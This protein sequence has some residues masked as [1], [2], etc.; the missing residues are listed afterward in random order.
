MSAPSVERRGTVRAALA[1]LSLAALAGCQLGKKE[2]TQ[3]GYRGYA[4]ELN[5]SAAGLQASLVSNRVPAPLPPAAPGPVPSP[6]PFKNVQVLNDVSV[7]EFTRT[8]TAMS[9]WVAPTTGA[10]AGCLYCHNAANFAADTGYPQAYA[11]VVARRMLQM[12]RH[13]N[14]D[15]SAHVSYTGV[16]CYTCHR[17]QPQPKGLWWF[18]E[19]DEYLRAYL[20]RND[21]RVQSH[22]VGPTPENRSSIK[23]TNW[24]YALMI[25]QTQALGVN[26]T[27]CHSSRQFQSWEQGG[28]KRVIAEY[29][30]WMV[31]DLNTSYLQPLRPV[32]PTNLV[33]SRLG[34]MGDGPKLQC[35]TCHNGVYKP[36]YGVSMAKDYPALWGQ[37]TWDSS[38]V[39]L[40]REVYGADA[41]HPDS[42]PGYGHEGD[43]VA[44]FGSVP[45]PLPAPSG[46]SM[47][48]T[49]TASGPNVQP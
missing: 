40:H 10:N 44:P 46:G 39:D 1:V 26:C 30:F 8:M 15:W 20:D 17:G 37:A 35:V 45:P 47:P 19:E 23:Q 14:H 33:P 29:G 16:T 48:A 6:S 22:T 38:S 13:I 42:T 4:K 34:A 49:P 7:A 24:T 41:A 27:Y 32:W 11:K 31:R 21:I 28:P 36:L 2:T 12:T 18:T 9:N 5:Y 43:P 25:N 3:E